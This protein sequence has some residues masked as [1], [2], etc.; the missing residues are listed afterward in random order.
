M[1]L[2]LNTRFACLVEKIY[3]LIRYDKL[4]KACIPEINGMY[5]V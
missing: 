2:M 1:L 3:N 4:T 5:L